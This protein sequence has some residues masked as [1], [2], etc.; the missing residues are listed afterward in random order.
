MGALWRSK[1][2]YKAPE[3]SNWV[4]KQMCFISYY[5]FNIRRQSIDDVFSKVTRSRHFWSGGISDASVP[6]E[7]GFVNI[8]KY[9]NQRL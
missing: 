6:S 9:A 1:R 7:L 4:I 2:V 5:K 8:W 3:S